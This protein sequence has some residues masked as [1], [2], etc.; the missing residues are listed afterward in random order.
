MKDIQPMD[1]MPISPKTTAAGPSSAALVPSANSDLDVRVIKPTTP[2]GVLK[3]MERSAPLFTGRNRSTDPFEIRKAI[4]RAARLQPNPRGVRCRKGLVGGVPGE[5]IEPKTGGTSQVLVYLHGGGY[6]G[7]SPATHRLMVGSLVRRSGFKAFVPDYRLA[8]EHQPPAQLEDARAVFERIVEVHGVNN[9]VL[10][11]DSAGGGLAVSLCCSLRDDHEPM[12]TRLA[13]LSPWVDLVAPYPHE[14][15]ERGAT[16]I[17]MGA[18][19][20]AATAE[21]LRPGHRADPDISPIYADLRG[22]PPT[23]I[24]VGGAELI[25]FQGEHL[26]ERLAEAGVHVSLERWANM[27]HVFQTIYILPERRTALDHIAAFLTGNTL[28][29]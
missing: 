10:A 22:L 14:I 9:V 25:G 5:W 16:D 20:I 26:A 29:G 3:A 13:L 27:Q 23:L 6:I 7:G 8:P 19:Q 17:V 4:D 11:G 21:L 12:P 24:Q 15:S 28:P 2:V 1:P 18:D